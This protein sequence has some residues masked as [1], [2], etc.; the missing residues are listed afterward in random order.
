MLRFKNNFLWE[1]MQISKAQNPIV[2]FDKEFWE[3]T[4]RAIKKTRVLIDCKSPKIIKKE[5]DG[6]FFLRSV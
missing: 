3:K 6:S 5:R 4:D 1:F 2:K